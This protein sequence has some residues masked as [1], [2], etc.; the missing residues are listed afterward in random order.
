MTENQ[1]DTVNS[2]DT[3]MSD[4]DSMAFYVL[5]D[6]KVVICKTRK[7]VPYWQNK[8]TYLCVGRYS[9]KFKKVVFWPDPVGP[10]RAMRLLEESNHIGDDYSYAVSGSATKSPKSKVKSPIDKLSGV[11]KRSVEVLIERGMKRQVREVDG[12]KTNL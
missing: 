2:P 5:R 10:T 4:P 9:P 12:K 11:R 6:E 3:L 8:T 7:D 1:Q